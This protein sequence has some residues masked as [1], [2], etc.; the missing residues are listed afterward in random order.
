MLY[1][2]A[3][4]CMFWGEG[5]GVERRVL[6]PSALWDYFVHTGYIHITF[7]LHYPNCHYA[8]VRCC[9]SL[10]G[11]SMVKCRLLLLEGNDCSSITGGGEFGTH[12]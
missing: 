9:L 4:V 11:W 3:C 12:K 5:V 1:K 10:R 6:C 8:E 7:T 2:H